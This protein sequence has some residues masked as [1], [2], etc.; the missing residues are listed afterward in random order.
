MSNMFHPSVFV[1]RMLIQMSWEQ[2]FDNSPGWLKSMKLPGQSFFT[3]CYEQ[4]PSQAKSRV[5]PAV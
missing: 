1:Y 4:I 3:Q 2:N 5:Y